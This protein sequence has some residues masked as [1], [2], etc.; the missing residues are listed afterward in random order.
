[1]EYRIRLRAAG[2]LLAALFCST[3]VGDTAPVYREA[4]GL[5]A[6]AAAGKIQPVEQRLPENPMLVEP[7]NAVGV[8]GG[9]WHMAMRDS[10]DH[11]SLIRTIG[12]ENL[13]RWTPDWGEAIPNVAQSVE[14]SADAREFTLAL[15]RGMRW[16]DGA[17][18]T[19][20]DILFWYED[21]LLNP[22]L[23]PS[24][25][26]WLLS[27]GEPVLVRKIDDHTVTF[28]FKAPNSLFLQLLAAPEGA[29]PTAYPKH[30]LARLLPKYN[31]DLSGSDW[32]AQF[33]AAYG[34]PGNVDDSTRWA[35]PE[36]PT[37]NAW[38]LKA[39][40]GSANP[41][42]AE[43]NPYYWKIDTAGQQLPYIDQVSFAVV[44][45]RQ[46]AAD[47]AMQGRIDMQARHVRCCGEQILAARSE[48][49]RLKIIP[50]VTN[51]LV[52]SL[53]LNTANPT[54]R[55]VF[56]QRDFR[57]AL[58]IGVD[59]AR[60]IH[61]DPKFVAW[62]VA[63]LPQSRHYH[64]R[65]ATQHI[66][67]HPG[68]ANK[69]LDALGY[70]RRDKDGWRLGPDGS[71]IA[72]TI[73][74]FSEER[75][76]WLLLAREDWRALGIDVSIQLLERED[77]VRRLESNEFD[78]A[79]YTGDGGIDVVVFPADFAPLGLQTA[80]GLKWWHWY[81]RRDHPQAEVPP[82][83]VQRQFALYD[84]IKSTADPVVQRELMR[85]ILDIAAEEFYSIGLLRITF[86]SAIVRRGM[87]N[88]P[89][90]LINSWSYPEPA[91]T[92]PAQYF[93]EPSGQ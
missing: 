19:A 92:N 30:H 20:D 18:F 52:I 33:H 48:Y 77:Y 28:R 79:G 39:G 61:A 84:S 50:T 8:Y 72:F 74:C 9:T 55:T 86:D 85:Q 46:A 64:E 4:P 71:P 89:D 70:D 68:R 22:E 43:R 1:M 24:I 54:L 42:V 73:N 35:H 11:A 26:Y 51:E 14:T 63:P 49:D 17:P 76:A 38:I 58:S 47:L 45:D 31:Q 65:L 82:L 15:R 91:P 34:T 69:L 27:E 6:L 62:Q 93:F 29:E 57:I 40:Y 12:Y 36:V 80:W 13:M 75:E 10:F 59:R 3:A 87:R 25:P 67:Y 7:L 56:N 32:P 41:L 5:A 60:M 90:F 78:A 88:V 2:A 81:Q 53:N 23:T 16:S 21:I 37:L 83:S 66:E 44:K